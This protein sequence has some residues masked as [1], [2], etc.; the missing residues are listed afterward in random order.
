M[1]ELEQRSGKP[2]VALD[3]MAIA[4]VT[5]STEKKSLGGLACVNGVEYVLPIPEFDAL[6]VYARNV[7]QVVT[8]AELNPVL[9]PDE[10]STDKIYNKRRTIIHTLIH[11]LNVKSSI[12]LSSGDNAG[13]YILDSGTSVSFAHRGDLVLPSKISIR[14]LDGLI[15]RLSREKNEHGQIAASLGLNEKLVVISLKKDQNT[16]IQLNGSASQRRQDDRQ[17]EDA[18]LIWARAK[19]IELL[20]KGWKEE[21]IAK[22][23]G[24]AVT[25]VRRWVREEFA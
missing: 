23:L 5:P 14:K 9:F 3:L 1:L 16:H 11:K 18:E 21:R 22:N 10:I 15:L 4:P 20:G 13:E 2:S 17:D 8:P 24:F 6:E 7:G 25:A 12:L 19:A